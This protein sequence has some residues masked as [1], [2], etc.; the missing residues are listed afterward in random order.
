MGCGSVY[1]HV[2][3]DDVV[4]ADLD[5]G[6]F[7]VIA[8]ML[9]TLTD[10]RAAVDSVAASHREWAAQMHVR[11][12]DTAWADTDPSFNHHE[13]PYPDVVGQLGLGRNEGSG[14]NTGAGRV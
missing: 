2:L 14:M 7:L 6:L 10:D 11:P 13:G 8:Q 12:Q 3:S 5:T 4:V 1:R 9:G